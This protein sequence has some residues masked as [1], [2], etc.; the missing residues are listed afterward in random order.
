MRRVLVAGLLVVALGACR[1]DAVVQ[2]D[3]HEDG[4]GTLSVRLS[5]D[6]DA[7]RAAEVDGGTLETRVR[8][9]DLAAAGW[10]VGGWRR[11]G[12]G[13]SVTLRQ[14]FA[15]PEEAGDLVA[16]LN[17]PDGP[18]RHVELTR[19]LGAFRGHWG[20]RGVG[21]GRVLDPGVT[22]DAQLVAR[23]TAE[24]VDVAGLEVALAR[25]VQDAF[26][27]RVTISLPNAAPKAFVVPAGKRVVMTTS[28][29]DVD[30]SHVAMLA[31]GLALAAGAVVLLL[32]GELRQRR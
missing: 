25:Q 12:S 13:A 28:S 5:L 7:V 8:L 9:E 30:Y 24:R 1:V 22:D 4:S 29:S 15:T 10:H 20:F 2:V 21:D 17:G 32:V 14:A 23:L 26:H 11:T 19:D 31:G 27:L 16:E 6:A 18:L 3:M